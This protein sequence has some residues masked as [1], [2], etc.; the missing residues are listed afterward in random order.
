MLRVFRRVKDDHTL[1]N[2]SPLLKNSC[3][4]HVVLDKTSGSPMYIIHIY[5]YI[6]VCIHII[7]TII[8]MMII[9]IT[10]IIIHVATSDVHGGRVLRPHRGRP[11]LRGGL[12]GLLSYHTISY[13]V[14]V[15]CVIS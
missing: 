3:V 12:H 13:Y 8:L 10:Q 9:N 2:Y 4:K 1:S 11:P 7:T 6:Y 15:C 5:I 14:I